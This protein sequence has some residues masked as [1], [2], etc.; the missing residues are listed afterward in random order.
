MIEKYNQ[1]I[2]ALN[3]AD[4][5][6]NATGEAA[7]AISNSV[8]QAN[9]DLVDISLAANETEKIAERFCS[10]VTTLSGVQWQKKRTQHQL[11]QQSVQT[12]SVQLQKQ[13]AAIKETNDKVIFHVRR[14]PLVVFSPFCY[15]KHSAR[16]ALCYNF[17]FF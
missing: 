5:A 14:L 15:I 13:S 16:A 17:N 4:A 11:A 6:N 8:A 10:A 2:F 3:Q 7:A 1:V 12:D 9:Q